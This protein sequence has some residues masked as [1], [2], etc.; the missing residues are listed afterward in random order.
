MLRRLWC[1]I[2]GHR[3]GLPARGPHDLTY[4]VCL[5]CGWRRK[6]RITWP[7]IRASEDLEVLV[8]TCEACGWAA[9]HPTRCNGTGE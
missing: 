3:L 2:V 6:R 1:W 7:V 9:M 4:E 8:F 5:R